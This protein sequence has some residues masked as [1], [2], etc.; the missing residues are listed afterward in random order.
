MRLASSWATEARLRAP[1]RLSSFE[2]RPARSRARACYRQSAPLVEVG[3]REG[4]EGRV[5]VYTEEEKETEEETVMTISLLPIICA[6]VGI[7]LYA[8]APNAKAAE[9]GRL[10]FFAGALAALLT[11]AHS[12]S[13]K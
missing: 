13:I 9:I 6:V 11:G 8:G 1:A 10:L 7:L 2:A 4:R 3:G 5:E 12:I